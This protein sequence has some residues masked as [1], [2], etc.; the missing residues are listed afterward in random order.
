[1]ANEK[2]D[3]A[4]AAAPATPSAKGKLKLPIIVGGMMLVEAV[5]VFM[6]VKMTATPPPEVHAAEGHAGEHGEPAEAKEIDPE[7]PLV[8]CESINR[9]S[10]QTIVVHLSLSALAA[11]ENAE[12]L[13]KLVEMRKSS[14]Q[15][16]VQFV[17]RGADP[18]HL[19]EPGLET[20]R[21]QLKAEIDKLFGDEKLVTELLIPQILQSRSSL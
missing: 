17:V 8:E 21:R 7:I 11:A 4:P 20:I 10:G 6:L 5:V 3:A 15:D 1:M 12:K 2:S 14:I 18:K 16:R 19:N 9:T 13:K